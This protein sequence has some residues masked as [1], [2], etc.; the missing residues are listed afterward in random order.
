MA[1]VGLWK[2]HRHLARAGSRSCYSLGD[3]ARAVPVGTSSPSLSPGPAA[4]ARSF[5]LP[6]HPSTLTSAALPFAHCCSRSGAR[7]CSLD[8]ASGSPGAWALLVLGPSA[9]RG[10][11]AVSRGERPHCSKAVPLGGTFPSCCVCELSDRPADGEK[12]SLSHP[13]IGLGLEIPW[14][15]DRVSPELESNEH[16]P[17][18]PSSRETQQESQ[19]WPLPGGLGHGGGGAGGGPHDWC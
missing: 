12:V 9:P 19:A 15:G 1:H 16:S 17:A 10:V 6:T 7:P 5:Q 14:N 11:T 4:G 18:P 3:S 2:D 8:P 13:L